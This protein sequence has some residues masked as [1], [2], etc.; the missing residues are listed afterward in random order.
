MYS[1]LK[2]SHRIFSCH[3]LRTENDTDIQSKSPLQ[4]PFSVDLAGSAGLPRGL[5]PVSGKT[6]LAM[7]SV[8]LAGFGANGRGQAVVSPVFSDLQ[9]LPR[10]VELT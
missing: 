1:R 7:F 10:S 9:V 4:R 3:P 8:D 5:Y 6:P 2:P